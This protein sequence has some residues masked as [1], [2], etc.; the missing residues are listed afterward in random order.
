[1]STSDRR[2][3]GGAAPRDVELVVFDLDGTLVNAFE[4]I[5]DAVN[6]V[7]HRFDREPMS[8]AQVKKF[9][10]HGARRLVAGVLNTDDAN[11]VGKAYE[12]LVQF[13][14]NNPSTNAHLYD[15]VVETLQALRRNRVKMA[16]TSNKPHVVTSQVVESMRIAQYLDAIRGEDPSLPRKPA[17][18]MLQFVMRELGKKPG[19]T[20]VVGDSDVDVHFARAASCRVVGVTYGQYGQE[21]MKRFEPDWIINAMPELVSLLALQ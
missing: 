18:D 5:A 15:G 17:P 14:A 11:I 6:H 13:Y 19:T 2:P 21:D 20:L 8:V 7:L 16:V 3:E 1:M 12:V 4:D 9:V 10:G